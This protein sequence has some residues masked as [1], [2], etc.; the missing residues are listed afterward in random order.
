MGSTWVMNDES[1]PEYKNMLLQ[2][3]TGLKWVNETFG[4][5][6]R[7]AWQIDPFGN[8][9]VT[10]SLFSKLGYEG[11]ILS[12]IGTTLYDNLQKSGSAEFVWSGVP[13]GTDDET[14]EL[15]AHALALSR[16]SAP[17]EF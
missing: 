1:L 11:I 16:Y 8:S 4:V 5:H 3:E 9:A 6:P 2:M 17:V 14:N 12:R 15:F 10:P 7:V 13:I